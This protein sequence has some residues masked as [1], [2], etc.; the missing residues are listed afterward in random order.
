MITNWTE[1]GYVGRLYY[2][3]IFQNS[4]KSPS[5]LKKNLF[6][7]ECFK[8]LILA[9]EPNSAYTVSLNFNFSHATRQETSDGSVFGNWILCDQKSM[10]KKV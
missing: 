9:F 5:H 8:M 2:S 4:R 1:H 3:S 10:Q 6:L 7:K